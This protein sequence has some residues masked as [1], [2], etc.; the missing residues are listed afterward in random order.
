MSFLYKLYFW[1]SSGARSER[2]RDNVFR[3]LTNP[4]R[5]LSRQVHHYIRLYYHN[6]VSV[7]GKFFNGFSQQKLFF[8]K[9][10]QF[11]S[12]NLLNS[13]Y[14]IHLLIYLQFKNS[15]PFLHSDGAHKPKEKRGVWKIQHLPIQYLKK[16][17]CK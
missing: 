9:G 6:N 14:P 12:T 16:Y 15:R 2:R 1:S 13:N 8:L 3:Q 5:R 17:Q 11:I 7:N 4:N 10:S